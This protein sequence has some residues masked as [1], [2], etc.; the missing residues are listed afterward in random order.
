MG[1]LR[2]AWPCQA[3]ITGVDTPG[4]TGLQLVFRVRALGNARS[5]RRDE[6]DYTDRVTI[7]NSECPQKVAEKSIREVTA[8]FVI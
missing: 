3:A 8:G 6:V 5:F 2:A 4:S 1:L 7:F